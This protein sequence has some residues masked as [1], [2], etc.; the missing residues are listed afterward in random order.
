MLLD[1]DQT[2]FFKYLDV[3]GDRWA[4]DLEILGY[5]IERQLVSSQQTQ[6]RSS[7]WVSDR[8]KNVSSH[9]VYL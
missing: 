2:T 4:A 9:V 6:Y 8:L 5:S 7:V 1:F 3:S